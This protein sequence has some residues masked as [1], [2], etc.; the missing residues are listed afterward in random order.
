MFQE[1]KRQKS[2]AKK[3]KTKNSLSQL[4]RKISDWRKTNTDKYNRD[5]KE[6]WTEKGPLKCHWQSESHW[7]TSGK[8][9]HWREVDRSHTERGEFCTGPRYPEHFPH[10][11]FFISLRS[12]PKCHLLSETFPNPPIWN[13]IPSALLFHPHALFS[14]QHLSPCMLLTYICLFPSHLISTPWEQGFMSSVYHSR[15]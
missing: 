8:Q 13:C 5:V 4:D 14:S 15:A 11:C 6:K 12:L 9:F 10:G 3:Q 7:W 1:N 2:K